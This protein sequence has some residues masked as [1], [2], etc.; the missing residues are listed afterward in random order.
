MKSNLTPHSG[1]RAQTNGDLV[2]LWRFDEVAGS[3]FA[4]ESGNYGLTGI[5][6][7]T[8]IDGL[9]G[10]NNGGF[11][12]LLFNGST[13]YASDIPT[14]SLKTSIESI[15][16]G[17]YTV[18]A[19]FASNDTT[20]GG[21]IVGYG[22]TSAASASH[23]RAFAV[24]VDNGEIA[25]EWD[26]GT[27][28]IV[29]GVTSGAE[30]A[31]SDVYHLGMIVRNAADG[32]PG[33][34]DVVID[35]WKFSDGSH[36]TQT[37]L[38]ETE[39]VVGNN[40]E[41][42]I[43]V[44]RDPRISKFFEGAVDD[45]R[46]SA[47][48]LSERTIRFSFASGKAD[49]N[50]E[51]LLEIG[52]GDPE[53]RVLVED[54]DGVMVDITSIHG[55][56][57]L[58][59]VSYDRDVDSDFDTGSFSAWRAVEDN[60]SIAREM[61]SSPWNLNAAGSYDPILALG[62]RIYVETALV[63]GGRPIQ[64]WMFIPEFDGVITRI[65]WGK[66]EVSV[67]FADPAYAFS[68]ALIQTESK[69]S[70]G[71]V[72]DIEDVIA[73]IVADNEPPTGYLGGF[74]VELYVPTPS[75]AAR[76][77]YTQTRVMVSDA[78]SGEANNIGWVCKYLWDDDRVGFRLT[79]E[80]PERTKTI[81]DMTVS[82]IS[83]FTVSP[84]TVDLAEIRNKGAV[85]VGSAGTSDTDGGEI[86]T[87]ATREDSASI[88]KYGEHAFIISNA[89]NIDTT[90]EGEALLDAIISD[91]SEPKAVFNAT[92]AFNRFVEIGDLIRFEADGLNT[93]ADID[94]AVTTIG[95]SWSGGI[96]TTTLGLRGKPSGR[97][98]AWKGIMM[99]ADFNGDFADPIT[100]PGIATS[101]TVAARV[102]GNLISWAPGAR[103]VG[104]RNWDYTE[105][106]IG[107]TAGFT[108]SS[109][110]LVAITRSNTYLHVTDPNEE[111][112]YKIIRRDI[113]GYASAPA[114]SSPTSSVTLWTP[115]LP[116]MSVARSGTQLITA[117]GSKV[118]M[119][120][121]VVDEN[122][123]YDD[124]A[125]QFH[126]DPP[127]NGWYSVGVRVELESAN[128]IDEIVELQI[129][130]G[131]STVH[132]RVSCRPTS[133]TSKIYSLEISGV[134]YFG[135]SFD[136]YLYLE[137]DHGKLGDLLISSGSTVTYW[138]ACLVGQR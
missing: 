70:P 2:A 51:T 87:I 33:E 131:T 130:E 61:R 106:H 48:A 40:A 38:N 37:F 44:G 41:C 75:G 1:K 69:Y 117:S 25:W 108:P 133:P 74:D 53:V 128:T 93:D 122:N 80:E 29:S 82:A 107:A 71:A 12:A 19:W 68:R 32:T 96:P 116:A 91:S 113:N 52:E 98:S 55:F 31:E 42:G 76:K 81:P 27:G 14:G 86:I 35:L 57:I 7:P 102:E 30:I 126:M 24:G 99:S 104:S 90:T 125:G 20:T 111:H 100:P 66:P 43:R 94:L 63:P 62:R 49:W 88:A 79:F 5:N 28:T 9:F 58:G 73:D 10:V 8:K 95:H 114:A 16:S 120:V 135:S 77:E 110:T 67:D 23:N 26:I 13:Q 3:S 109:S 101:I 46:I 97:A 21:T 18:E 92:I 65:D 89:W 6:S 138:D 59:S 36:F 60:L 56:D 134:F 103:R 34:K 72:D 11:G 129:R 115:S 39:A 137:F 17:E 83:P 4:D 112:F 119:N 54:G 22:G 45:I 105:I 85:K 127:V 136:Y 15:L 64:E 78:Y 84:A 47:V 123:L 121:E 124:G 118:E 132:R 50:E